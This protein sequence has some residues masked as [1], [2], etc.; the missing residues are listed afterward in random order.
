MIRIRCVEDSLSMSVSGSIW[1]SVWVEISDR[2]FPE[3][4]WNDMVVALMC[5]FRQ[6]AEDLRSPPV[7]RRRVRFFDGPVWVDIAPGSHRGIRVTLGGAGVTGFSVDNVA[8]EEF[9]SAV[10][11][12]SEELLR[13]LENRGWMDEVDVRRLRALHGR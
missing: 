2:V 5:E 11:L 9:I 12:A 1:G 8:E 13:A 10:R 6:L 3:W 7:P 4:C